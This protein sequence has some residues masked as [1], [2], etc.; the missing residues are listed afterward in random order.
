MASQL[1]T[2]ELCKKEGKETLIPYDPVGIELMKQHLYSEHNLTWLVE[3]KDAD[4]GAR[5]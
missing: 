1:L 3:P 4:Y 2:C 5:T